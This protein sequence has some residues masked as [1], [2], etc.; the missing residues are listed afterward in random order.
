MSGGSFNYLYEQDPPCRE[1]VEKMAEAIRK[2]GDENHS[3]ARH[4]AEDTLR[5]IALFEEDKHGNHGDIP[6]GVYSL[7]DM[8]DLGQQ[9]GWCPYFLARQ[10][11]NHANILVYN[12]QYMLD[13]KVGLHSYER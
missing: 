3:P 2:Y 5:V 7:D 9:K 12:Y 11:I 13:P 4:A 8:K 10:L 6:K 1:T